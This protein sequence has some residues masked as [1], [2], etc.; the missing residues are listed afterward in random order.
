MRGGSPIAIENVDGR[1]L[2]DA[3]GIDGIVGRVGDLHHLLIFGADGAEIVV[4]SGDN[5]GSSEIATSHRRQ[6]TDPDARL[7]GFPGILRAGR[8]IRSKRSQVVKKFPPYASH[9]GI[10]TKDLRGA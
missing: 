8:I 5:P 10:D 9:V 6:A 7:S 1:V 2:A 4:E 3:P